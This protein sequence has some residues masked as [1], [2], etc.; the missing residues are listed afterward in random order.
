[1]NTQ[2]IN[3]LTT[4]KALA[5][6]EAY[7]MGE[8]TSAEDAILEGIKIGLELSREVYT[9]EE[10]FMKDQMFNAQEVI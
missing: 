8:F 7:R 3:E 1:M 5:L 4:K 9:D 6:I 10:Q 2:D